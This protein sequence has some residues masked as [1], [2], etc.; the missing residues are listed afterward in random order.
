MD[1]DAMITDFR[2]EVDRLTEFYGK[3]SSV[4]VGMITPLVKKMADII[5]EMQERINE[6][7]EVEYPEDEGEE[8]QSDAELELV[9]ID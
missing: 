5:E 3:G 6:I 1:L 9:D 8:F 2:N 4:T 7:A